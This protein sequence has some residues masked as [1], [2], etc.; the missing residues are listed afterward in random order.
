MPVK[1]PDTNW[2]REQVGPKSRSG[3]FGGEKNLLPLPGSKFRLKSH[4]K[5]L[6]SKYGPQSMTYYSS[7]PCCSAPYPSTGVYGA[8]GQCDPRPAFM[9]LVCGHVTRLLGQ[10]I[11]PPQL[12]QTTAQ[13]ENQRE[14]ILAPTID[15]NIRPDKDKWKVNWS[16]YKPRCDPESG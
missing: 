2:I 10:G 12:P 6:P 3:H 1:E 4:G 9:N 7:C 8:I 14:F 5:H 16:R 13:T 15:P 11:G